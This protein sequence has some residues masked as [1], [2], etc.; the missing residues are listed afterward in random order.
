MWQPWVSVL[1]WTLLIG[2][3]IEQASEV[4]SL[5]V[6]C[7]CAQQ[8]KLKKLQ[9]HCLTVILY[10][11]LVV[12]HVQSL[13]SP[14]YW[15]KNAW[16]STEARTRDSHI[17]VLIGTRK[18]LVSCMWIVRMCPSSILAIILWKTSSV[19]HIKEYTLHLYDYSM[20]AQTLLN[21]VSIKR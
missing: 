7:L 5:K 17:L 4:W 20:N 8:Q 2:Y 11:Q 15:E 16:Y 10:P 9:G 1:M 19:V 3:Q 18:S 6:P 21:G 13:P 12:S 14:S